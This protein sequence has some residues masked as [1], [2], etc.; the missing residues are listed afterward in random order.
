MISNFLDNKKT[1]NYGI[2][3]SYQFIEE[4]KN[5][6]LD[7]FGEIDNLLLIL[8]DYIREKEWISL[9]EKNNLLGK[10]EYA[11]VKYA[12]VKGYNHYK[13]LSKVFKDPVYQ[14]YDIDNY[15]TG[16]YN[17]LWI[18]LRSLR[19]ILEVNQLS[20]KERKTILRD[21]TENKI[22]MVSGYLEPLI[23]ICYDLLDSPIHE[24]N[25]NEEFLPMMD[26]YGLSQKL[27][28]IK[29]YK[30]SNAIDMYRIITKDSLSEVK[31][32]D[33]V[34]YL[35]PSLFPQDDIWL[36]K[37]L[38]NKGFT[39]SMDR[40][41]GLDPRNID[42]IV[43]VALSSLP[44]DVPIF[45]SEQEY[46]IIGDTSTYSVNTYINNKIYKLEYK[47]ESAEINHPIVCKYINKI[48]SD[49]GHNNKLMLVNLENEDQY[50]IYCNPADLINAYNKYEIKTT[51]TY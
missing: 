4:C 24:M 9:I 45:F 38:D 42:D 22:H 28:R 26:I 6:E 12:G 23:T 20:N 5:E 46:S 14:S 8:Y 32:R 34:S 19:E 48:L 33:W 2:A 43:I 41:L 17:R 29:D 7:Y 25:M 39:I 36:Q 11:Q 16:T 50:W 44:I 21:L 1:R 51:V 3:K 18:S 49:L 37:L 40:K 47:A 31:E 35:Q 27:Q 13:D 15:P 10:I 30:K